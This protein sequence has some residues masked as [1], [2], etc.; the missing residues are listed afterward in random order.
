MTSVGKVI[1][2]TSRKGGVGK[3]TTLLN[4][5]GCY[6]NLDKKVII[7]DFDLYTNSISASLNLEPQKN[8][9]NLVDDIS[10]N[11]FKDK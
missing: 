3:T 8:I 4:L 1:T 6:S 11:R 9:F 10:N 2:I 5:A 7:L